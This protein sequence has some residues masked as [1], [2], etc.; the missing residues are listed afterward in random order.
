MCCVLRSGFGPDLLKFES[1]QGQEICL[2]SKTYRL[3][4]E[5][6]QSSV[7]CVCGFF[8]GDKSARA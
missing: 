7:E 1:Q 8:P 6:I 2:F 3:V 4:L 5:P